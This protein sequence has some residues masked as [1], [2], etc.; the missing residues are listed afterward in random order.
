MHDR[1]PND[2]HFEDVFGVE[3]AFLS[4]RFNESG[5]TLNDRPVDRFETSRMVRRVRDP[6]HDIFTVDH[7][8]VHDRFGG[9][10]FS[11]LKMA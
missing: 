3:I 9:D 10:K 11:G 8:G 2:R 1:V 5:Q 6:R 7:L 4:Y